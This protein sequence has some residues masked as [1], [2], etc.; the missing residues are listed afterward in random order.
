[1][2]SVNAKIL[3]I[4]TVSLV[5]VEA[6]ILLFTG[7][8]ERESFI[9][10]YVFQASIIAQTA[11][12]QRLGDEE[13]RARLLARLEPESVLSIEPGPQEVS[14]ELGSG[15][16]LRYEGYGAEIEIDAGNIGPMTA[17]F[18]WN[19]I[20]VVAIIVFFMVVTSFFFL[21]L[22]VVRPLR[23]LLAGFNGVAGSEGDLTQRLSLTTQDEVGRIGSAF[24]RFVDQIAGTVARIREATSESSE[25]SRRLRSEVTKTATAVVDASD[26]VANIGARISSQDEDIRDTTTAI[27]EISGHIGT[28]VGSAQTQRDAVADALASVEQLNQS[29]QS[30]N[31]IAE[32][33]RTAAQGLKN[34]AVDGLQK[35]RAS[36]EAIA[37]MEASTSEMLGLIDVIHEVAGQTNLLSLNAAIEAAH[38]GESGKGFA[39]VAEEI[40]KLAGQTADHA[41]SI[42]ASLKREVEGIG[43]AAGANRA[44][45]DL[46]EHTVDEI[47]GL[48]GSISEIV[49]GLSEQLVATQEILRAEQI[50]DGV[51]QQTTE[52]T[53]TVQSDIAT[54][55]GG[56]E[57]V[58]ENS[59]LIM[60]AISE[61]RDGLTEARSA[62]DAIS[63]RVAS[64]D[65]LVQGLDNEVARFKTTTDDV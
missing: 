59:R 63:D 11:D 4:L 3:L 7:G 35:M 55:R 8:N 40:R 14:W 30:L 29:I 42:D 61:V 1:M 21:N 49:A 10:H 25:T 36:V 64:N 16:I 37:Q 31:S 13:Y 43:L 50:I 22:W 19:T 56:I 9:N 26:S 28:M 48:V 46:F 33:R 2:R 38:A 54:V 57:Q 34:T 44:A 52:M 58:S 45:V 15:S 24:N 60:S 32:T 65:D 62:M 12:S 41:Q 5:L 53:G 27:T 23:L 51:A 17:R 18:I 6:I 20:G 47:D 39:V